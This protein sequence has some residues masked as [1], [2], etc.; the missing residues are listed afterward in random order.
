MN[1][2]PCR[3]CGACC[4]HDPVVVTN[5]ERELLGTF[6]HVGLMRRSWRDGRCLALVG[7][8]MSAVRCDVYDIRP[9][10]CRKFE[11]GSERC[12]AAIERAAA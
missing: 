5:S 2:P 7:E 6:Q 8:V 3:S 10:V 9:A 4:A 11:R 1:L 12:L